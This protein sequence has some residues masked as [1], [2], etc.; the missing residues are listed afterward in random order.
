MIEASKKIEINNAVTFIDKKELLNT[1][2]HELK[3]NDVVLVK[4]SRGM[5][6]EDVINHFA[7]HND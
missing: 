2:D 5:K 3:S 1:L 4:G 6:M 7:D